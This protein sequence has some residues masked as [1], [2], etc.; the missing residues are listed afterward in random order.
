MNSEKKYVTYIDH[1]TSYW[2]AES[3]ARAL[4]VPGYAPN[5][6]PYNYINLAFLLHYGPADAAAIWAHPTGFM[7]AT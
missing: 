5:D 2:G 3:I 7:D 6:L 1:L 4:W